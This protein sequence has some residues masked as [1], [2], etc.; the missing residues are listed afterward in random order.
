MRRGPAP[1]GKPSIPT[2]GRPVTMAS[3]PPSCSLRP[4]S[5]AGSPGSTTTASG[6]DAISTRVPSKSRKR[7]AGQ[8]EDLVPPLDATCRRSGLLLRRLGRGR[9]GP[10]CAL[11]A[12]ALLPPLFGAASLACA[13]AGEVLQRQ[14]SSPPHPPETDETADL[15][16][17]RARAAGFPDFG[18]VRPEPVEPWPSISARACAQCSSA[19]RPAVRSP[20]RSGERGPGSCGPSQTP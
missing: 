18:A 8:E 10:D 3:A 17:I 12:D 16:S 7:A 19:C 14:A 15:L 13:L 4:E 20:P 9:R 6:V 1:Q 5:R 2:I 11:A